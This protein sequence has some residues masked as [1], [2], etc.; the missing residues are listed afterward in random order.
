MSI[1]VVASSRSAI[2]EVVDVF[3]VVVV[4]KASRRCVYKVIEEGTGRMAWQKMSADNDRERKTQYLL[5]GRKMS[6]KAE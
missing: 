2:L 1:G 5:L 4:K 3:V 6:D